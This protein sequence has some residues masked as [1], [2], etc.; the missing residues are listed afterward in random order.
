MRQ[1]EPI[2]ERLGRA[3]TP[4]GGLGLPLVDDCGKKGACEAVT[5]QAGNFG[6]K[7]T[8]SVIK[9][10]TSAQLR[11]VETRVGGDL[12][13]FADAKQIPAKTVLNRLGIKV[14]S[15][16]K[17]ICPSHPNP[18][19][20]PSADFMREGQWGSVWTCRS[21]GASGSSIDLVMKSKNL[22]KVAAV[23]WILDKSE[24][25]KTA[26]TNAGE[27]EPDKAPRPFDSL[28]KAV[29]SIRVAGHRV[30]KI[31]VYDDRHHV[32]RLEEVAPA[33]GGKRRK[34][35]RPIHQADDGQWYV[36]KG[37]KPWP[38][39]G[40]NNLYISHNDA[41]I[42]IVEGE[43]A[44][45]AIND[46]KC[47]FYAVTSQGGHQSGKSADWSTLP[48]GL[49]ILIWPDNDKGGQIYA[50]A[51]I[52]GI[53]SVN[54]WP[55][56][57]IRIVGTD[58]W[59][60][61]WD[62]AD[63]L[64]GL[65][66]IEVQNRIESVIIN[67]TKVV[68]SPE[69]RRVD[70]A[71]SRLNEMGFKAASDIEPEPVEY[72]IPG[73]MARGELTLVT[74]DAGSGKTKVCTARAAHLTTGKSIDGYPIRNGPHKVAVLS[75][76]ECPKRT[77]SPVCRWSGMDMG[78]AM[79]W[80]PPDDGPG[81]STVSELCQMLESLA[82]AGY[83]YILIDSLTALYGRLGYEVNDSKSPYV[84]HTAIN[85]VARSRNLCIEMI[86][87]NSKGGG[88]VHTNHQKSAGS[89][90]IFSSVRSV[91]Q[92]EH[93]PTTGTRFIGVSP[94][95]NNLGLQQACLAFRTQRVAEHLNDGQG[96]IVAEL[97]G[98]NDSETIDDISA[99]VMK[100]KNDDH[101]SKVKPVAVEVSEAIE[102]FVSKADGVCLVKDLDAHLLRAGYSSNAV[103]DGKKPFEKFRIAGLP[104]W[105]ITTIKVEVARELAHL[106]TPDVI[107]VLDADSPEST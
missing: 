59:P 63:E 48:A 83:A 38:L 57:G 91:L 78:N 21:C 85:R 29:S 60:D 33:E 71:V 49:P 31:F 90:A 77:I 54:L 95:K 58:G 65:S 53:A 100:A 44:A 94:N 69:Q 89:Y 101:R 52:E 9:D 56:Q 14:H 15:G 27:V 22:D 102:T 98:W 13:S 86:H 24:P 80:E 82:A 12:Q 75:F 32:V 45:D 28:E 19:K 73:V 47:R 92:V 93:D 76:E 11:K 88:Q 23:G 61:K 34:T 36:N 3:H 99:R 84:V 50:D 37:D 10:S 8:P 1:A 81:I 79:I 26:V 64:H 67:R 30:S 62:A 106:R 5:S 39:Y 41:I 87:H 4:K 20:N 55:D 72:L 42:I 18:D 7:G 68:T 107:E 96:Y 97:A 43:K 51:V 2:N 105:F 40:T 104:Q 16:G 103:R 6:Q 35:I 74:G 66:Q 46:A 17:F 25:I 70:S